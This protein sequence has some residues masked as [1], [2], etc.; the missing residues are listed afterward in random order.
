M[1]VISQEKGELVAP[2]E[3]V[4]NWDATELEFLSKTEIQDRLFYKYGNK[5]YVMDPPKT[6]STYYEVPATLAEIEAILAETGKQRLCAHE[7]VDTGFRKS[8]CRHCN[9]DKP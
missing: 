6:P 8:W 2:K 7:W 3:L 9:E 1:C 4:I 5:L